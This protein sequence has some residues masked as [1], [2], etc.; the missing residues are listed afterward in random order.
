MFGPYL[1]TAV[2]WRSVMLVTWQTDGMRNLLTLIAVVALVLGVAVAAWRRSARLAWAAFL[3]IAVWVV[4]GGSLFLVRSS[5]D[6]PIESG[7]DIVYAVSAVALLGL[8][9]AVVVVAAVRRGGP[10]LAELHHAGSVAAGFV[11]GVAAVT[12]LALLSFGVGSYASAPLGPLVAAFAV[13]AL[14]ALT[15][16][17]LPAR[18]QRVVLGAAIVGYIGLGAVARG[19]PMFSDAEWFVVVP[20]ALAMLTRRSGVRSHAA[21]AGLVLGAATAALAGVIHGPMMLVLPSVAWPTSVV[22]GLVLGAVAV[23]AACSLY[24]DTASIW[25]AASAF[26]VG[27]LWGVGVI[28]LNHVGQYLVLC[29]VIILGLA[30]AQAVVR[31]RNRG[32][33]PSSVTVT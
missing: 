28:A 18:A 3:Y 4:S 19:V 32:G 9:T 17:W 14:P 20:L 7:L 30:A 1:A 27:V 11:G 29:G 22:A 5:G 16:R 15:D 33:G 6:M 23:A 8:L 21:T 25:V 26:S 24:A 13:V 12:A 2:S 31:L 10:R